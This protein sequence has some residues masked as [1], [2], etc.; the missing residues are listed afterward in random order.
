MFALSTSLR[1]RKEG[2]SK[3]KE[4]RGAST[5]RRLVNIWLVKYW[6]SLNVTVQ[7][8]QI[9]VHKHDAIRQQIAMDR[10]IAHY[11]LIRGQCGR[12]GQYAEFSVCEPIWGP[13]TS[14]LQEAAVPLDGLACHAIAPGQVTKVMPLSWSTYLKRSRRLQRMLRMRMRQWQSGRPGTLN[15]ISS[16][17]KC[18]FQASQAAK[19]S[20]ICT[21]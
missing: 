6:L 18:K 17:R 20:K 16:G 3:R 10:Q 7:N 19:C 14:H 8:E 12:Q 15:T 9:K 1:K 21:R 13:E 5:E 11:E 4:R 2:K